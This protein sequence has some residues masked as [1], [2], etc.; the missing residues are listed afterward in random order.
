MLG[1]KKS[2]LLSLTVVAL[3]L[4]LH[5]R[6]G[7]AQLD[8]GNRAF[9]IYQREVKVGEI[10]RGEDASGSEKYVEH[11]VL[12]DNYVY[13]SE[14]NGIATELRPGGTEYRDTSDFLARVPWEKGYRYVRVDCND[15][16]TLPGR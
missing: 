11:W 9:D 13:P 5:P 16:A 7:H 12:F 14:R 3:M 2:W 8:V 1:L 10:Y 4:G 6:A 15:T